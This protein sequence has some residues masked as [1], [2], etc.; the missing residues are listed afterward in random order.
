LNEGWDRISRSFI[1]IQNKQ[2]GEKQIMRMSEGL[3]YM[4]GPENRKKYEVLKIYNKDEEIAVAETL[5]GQAQKDKK[6]I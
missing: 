4:V 2:T 6:P 1:L 5:Y 3:K